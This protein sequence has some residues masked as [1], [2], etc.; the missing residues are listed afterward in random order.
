MKLANPK[1]EK[2]VIEE[3]KAKAMAHWRLWLPEKWAALVAADRVDEALSNAARAAEKE[4]RQLM[5]AGAKLNEA[6]EM[7]LPEYILLP[8]ED[9]NADLDEESRAEL[10]QME[11]DYLEV[12]GTTEPEEE[13]QNRTLR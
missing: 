12:Y 3:L 4:I 13:F 2:A 9:E 7:V 8:P 6:E 1:T 10:A 5:R 11:A